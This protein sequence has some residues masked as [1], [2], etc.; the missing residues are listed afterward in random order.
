MFRNLNINNKLILINVAVFFFLAFLAVI[1]FLFKLPNIKATFLNLLGLSNNVKDLW[2]IW[3]LVTYMFTHEDFWHILGNMLWLYFMGNMLLFIIDSRSFFWLYLLGGIAGA[4]FYIIAFNIF[5]V[6]RET[7]AILIGAS[8]SVNAIVF[9]LTTFNPF[10]DV[11]LFAIFRIKLWVIAL[12]L[13]VWDVFSLPLGNAG[14]HFAHLGGALYGFLFAFY[15]RKGV[16]FQNKFFNFL[17]KLI[18]RR[19]RLKISYSKFRTHDDYD[20]TMNRN[21]IRKE[22]DR[23][24]DKIAKEGYKSLTRKEKKFL[25]DYSKYY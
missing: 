18:P 20:F 14:G 19:K 6:F 16:N 9:A 1:E 3:T 4:I 21:L 13:I 8:A 23:L 2:K 25:K 24:L 5:P 17:S 7:Y 10:Q 11:Y 15:L 22:I 12:F